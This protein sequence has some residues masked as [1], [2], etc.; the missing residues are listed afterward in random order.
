MHVVLE[1]NKSPT[2]VNVGYPWL[3]YLVTCPCCVASV[4]LKIVTPRSKF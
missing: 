3:V 4:D 2:G 1:D